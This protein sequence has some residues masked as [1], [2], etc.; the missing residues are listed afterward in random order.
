MG[1]KQDLLDAATLLTSLTNKIT[2]SL[3][4]GDKSTESQAEIETQFWNSPSIELE[5]D[6]SQL[7]LT[8][9]HLEAL[10]RGPLNYHRELFCRPYEL[11]VFHVMVE[12]GVFLA[13]P[14]EGSI[15]LTELSD[16]VPF[17]SGKLARMLHFLSVQ[18]YLQEPKLD[19]FGHT[20]LSRSLATDDLM[21]AEAKF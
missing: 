12:F 10:V 4:D 8:L 20:F 21:H 3:P 1:L 15:S 19:V 18:G 17:D 2:Q 11:M 5:H 14:T 13:I 16:K 7:I 6:Q 9:K